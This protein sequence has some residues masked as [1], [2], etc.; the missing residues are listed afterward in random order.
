M[1][2]ISFSM[3]TSAFKDGSKSV[4]R[5][6]GWW[7][8]KPGDILMGVEKS[9]GLKKGEKVVR[10]GPIKIV[11][12]RHEP[13][14]DIYKEGISEGIRKEGFPNILPA[15]FVEKFIQYNF[16]K[17][18]MGGRTIVNRIEFKHISIC[19]ICQA[20][21]SDGTRFCADHIPC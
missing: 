5:R 2:N 9:Q 10:L 8:L 1:R 15:D 3:T 4:T 7:R 20:E 13:L 12:T 21:I 18:K 6:L 19:E 11:D 17:C 14:L 16:A